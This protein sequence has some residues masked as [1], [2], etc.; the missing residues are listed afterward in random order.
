MIPA[1]GLSTQPMP[2]PFVERVGST[3]APL[4]DYEMG[5]VALNDSS[6]GLRVKLWRVRVEG[7]AVY[8]RADGGSDQLMFSRP[9]ISEV[10]LAFDQN[11]QPVIAFVQNGSAWLWWFDVSIPGMVFTQFPGIT[12]PRVCMDDKRPGQTANS[13]VIMAYIR[14]GSLCY[15]QQRERYQV[16]TTLGGDVPCGGLAAVCMS[17]GGRLQFAFGGA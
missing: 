17:T 7:N 14:D 8:L 4:T 5:G 10:S 9:G 15:R 13:D 1:G 6:Q 3:L 12:N 16:E 2:A 11:M